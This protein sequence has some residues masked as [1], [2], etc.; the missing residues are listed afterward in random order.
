MR[1]SV[2]L[3]A[4]LAGVALLLAGCTALPQ[5]SAPQPFD[6]S[7]PDAA[8]IQ[9][10]ADGPAAG[11]D[12]TT[13]VR[14]F[15]LACAAGAT[16]DFA[17]AR[18]F[19]TAASAQTWDPQEQI[20]VYDADSSPRIAET[21]VP[22]PDSSSVSVTVPALA[23]VDARG[24]MSL[25]PRSS[26]DQAFDLVREGGE[27]RIDAPP[28]GLLIPRAS[29]TST[30]ELANL[31]FPATTGDALVADPRW[32]PARRLAGH[33]LAGLVDGPR[34]ALD[35]GVVNAIPGGATIPSQGVETVDR[36]AR[37][38]LNASAPADEPSRR[39]LAWQIAETLTQ[40]PSVTSVDLRVGGEQISTE[41]L[42]EPPAYDLDARVVLT[43]DGIGVLSGAAVSPLP[44]DTPP[45]PT[46]TSPALSPVGRDLVAWNEDDTLV[47]TRIADGPDAVRE[48]PGIPASSAASI[49]RFGWVWAV[50]ESGIVAASPESEPLP[51]PSEGGVDPR[52]V[53][54]SPDGARALVV[55]GGAD[56]SALLVATVER[57]A[58]GRPVALTSMEEAA[59][60][61][62]T[63]ID[64][65]WAGGD[66]IVVASRRVGEQAEQTITS[67]D[68]GG[69]ASSSP[70]P[71]EAVSL[72]AGAGP[73]A[74]CMTTSEGRGAC[75]SGAL[76][77]VLAPA[78]RAV[79]HAG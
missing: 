61:L 46:A 12:A 70:L 65:S 24:V 40:A 28:D 17:T 69:L 15:L 37:V 41:D 52:L 60:P 4:A 9:L 35:G 18:L 71:S 30:Y 50:G 27:W 34:E 48:V 3:V 47:I 39:L 38:V 6:V 74:P 5:A 7:V 77:Q 49:D 19:L 42:P 64:A 21:G 44:I 36:T 78:V 62:G 79:R 51:V 54:I 25:A 31:W 8:P 68:L 67:I 10:S 57:D 16:D 1:R 20:V 32:Y 45:P 63:T 26:V 59:P 33:L 22:S 72:S 14:D 75:R 43:D 56:Q 58:S 53:R 76:W 29:F 73:G 55:T 2:R 13:L 66:V 11:A 23:S